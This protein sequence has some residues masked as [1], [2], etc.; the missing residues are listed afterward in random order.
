MGAIGQTCIGRDKN[1]HTGRDSSPKTTSDLQY[2]P[3]FFDAVCGD[4][5][6]QKIFGDQVNVKEIYTSY[7]DFVSQVTRTSK[8]FASDMAAMHGTNSAGNRAQRRAIEFGKK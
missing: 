3:R 5:T 8:Q 1:V 2:N 6:A 4:G 7:N